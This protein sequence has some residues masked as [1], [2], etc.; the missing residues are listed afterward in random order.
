MSAFWD[1]AHKYCY[2]GDGRDKFQ[3]HT[4][5][6]RNED[7]AYDE[8]GTVREKTAHFCEFKYNKQ[9]RLALGC[10]Q[11]VTSV[12]DGINVL[13][14][15]R[16]KPYDYSG[17]TILAI[18]DFGEH[19]EKE[20]K[21]VRSLKGGSSFWT[22]VLREKDSLYL[23]ESINAL[24][25]V[26]DNRAQQMRTIGFHTVSD[27][28]R[29]CTNPVK[30]SELRCLK[31]VRIVVCSAAL[32]GLP[33][34]PIEHWKEGNPYR[35]K[36][37]DNWERE[38]AKSASMSPYVCITDLIQHIVDETSAFYK[39]TAYEHNW[40]FYHDSLSLLTA[41]GTVEWMKRKGY[42][43]CWIHPQLGVNDHLKQYK[44]NPPGNSPE[45]MPLDV[46]LFK[47]LHECVM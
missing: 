42:Y 31:G 38:V 32:H 5:F 35:S 46:S 27:F 26:G 47:D 44:D 25:L 14:G 29:L 37:G 16:L 22:E 1:E 3:L 12:V 13:V 9:V 30:M 28:K 40:K 33:P 8:R 20:I 10:A 17:K 7:G 45:M 15:C 4:K 21:H 6:T 24:R 36:Y 34:T 19:I 39:N 43:E 23:E 2:T 18:K 11:K 41:K